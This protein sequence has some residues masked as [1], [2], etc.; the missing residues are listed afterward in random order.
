MLRHAG[1]ATIGKL[2]SQLNI[3]LLST[4]G[5]SESRIPDAVEKTAKSSSYKGN[6]IPLSEAE[7]RE[8]VVRGM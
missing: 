7:L 6:P 8:V 4:L 1:H 3:P 2:I 5:T